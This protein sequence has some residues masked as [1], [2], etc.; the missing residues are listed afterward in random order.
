MKFKKIL[1]TLNKNQKRFFFI[2][3]ILVLLTAII[4]LVGIASII[5]LINLIIHDDLASKFP[6]IAS[7]LL[8]FSKLIIPDLFLENN[9]LKTN[10]IISGLSIFV[11]FYLFKTISLIVLNYIFV[12]FTNKI[13]LS[14]STGIYKGYLGLDYLFHTSKNSAYLKQNILAETNT[15]ASVFNSLLILISEVIILIS[16][17]CFLFFYNWQITLFVIT[18]LIFF[19]IIVLIFTKK[20]LSSWGKKRIQ[21]MSNRFKTI[22]EGLESIKEIYIYQRFSYFFNFYEKSSKLFFK[23]QTNYL[24][25]LNSTRPIFEFVGLLGLITILFILFFQNNSSDYLIATLGLFLAASLRL[26]PSLNKIIQSFQNI[27]FNNACIDR[28]LGEFETIKNSKKFL[29]TNTNIDFQSSVSFHNVGFTYPGKNEPVFNEV[30]FT[31]KKG[32]KIGIQGF[33]GSGK[34]TLVNL[35]LTLLKP[36]EGQ[37]KVD[38]EILKQNSL[39]WTKNIGY[40]AQSTTIID[41]TIKNNITFGIIEE[42][43]NEDKIKKAIESAQLSSFVNSLKEGTSTKVG[44][45]GQKISGG[46][47]QRIGIAR[48]LYNDPALLI[49]DEPTSALDLETEKL[50]IDTI[51]SLEKNKTIIIISHKKSVLSKCDKI[52][53]IENRKVLEI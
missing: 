51:F 23:A 15:F 33:S 6:K 41:D 17:S 40:V 35:I 9:S 27:R 38:N 25:T 10:Y 39:S 31:I 8:D 20:P 1:D 37:I 42:K 22:Q 46:Q 32:S 16:I 44:E 43:I 45:K 28:I 26:L 13:A 18:F 21:S 53:K 7:F 4:E 34:T 50:F 19:S 36:T 47:Q 29:T 11:L 24:V 12:N 48:A 2:I 52:L 3:I 5:P 14:I 49:L 30:D